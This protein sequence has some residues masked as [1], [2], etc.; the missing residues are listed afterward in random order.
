MLFI[1]QVLAAG[2]GI[3]LGGIFA[4][5]HH[6]GENRHHFGIIGFG[7]LVHFKLFDGGVY[8]ADGG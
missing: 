8:Q 5:L 1:G 6:F 4:L 3:N 2:V 7:A